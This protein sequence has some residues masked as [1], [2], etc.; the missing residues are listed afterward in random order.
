MSAWSRL[1]WLI[2]FLLLANLVAWTAISHIP[3]DR[4]HVSFL[5][6]GQ[7]D[8]ILIQTPGRHT[9]LIDGGPDP[10]RLLVELGRRMPFWSRSI[11]L[12]IATQGQADHIT[13]LNEV[14]QRYTV[15]RVL[16]PAVYPSPHNRSPACTEWCDLLPASVVERH[17]ARAGQYVD[18]GEGIS[19]EVV[20]PP[21]ALLTAASDPVDNNGTVMRLTWRHASFLFCA[22]IRADAEFEL[23]S[24]R[25]QLQSTVLKV[26]HHGS[27][28]SS[29]EQ[30]L[31]AVQP[32]FAVISAG[33]HNPFG[34]P[35]QGVTER[36]VNSVGDNGLFLTAEHGT[37]TFMTDG[38]SLTVQTDV[39]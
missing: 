7:G 19:L 8:A 14:L 1:R 31:K 12:V 18:L 15:P 22:D 28:T 10:E 17:A 9:I 36:L 35:D 38:V 32:D 20:S 16:E 5:D 4:L 24:R 29:S 37:I 13:G 26:A 27:K 6:V 33:A 3:D 34:H 21:A 30:F 2:P 39:Q 23:V 25:A 11:D